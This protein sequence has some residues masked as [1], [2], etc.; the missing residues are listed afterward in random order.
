MTS[1]LDNPDID[2]MDAYFE[3]MIPSSECPLIYHR[4][5]LISIVGA[6]LGRQAHLEFG[7]E[8]IYPNMYVC[9]IGSAG[10]RKSS[11][12]KACRLMLDTTGYAYF[13]RERT[14]KEKF[15]KDMS[16]AKDLPSGGD[17]NSA[18]MLDMD[19]DLNPV[20]DLQDADPSEVYV[21]AGELEDFLGQNDAGFISLLTNLWDNLDKYDHGKMTSHDILIPKPTVNLLG[22]ATSTTFNSVFPPEVIGQGMLSR[23]LLIFGG[24]KRT[25][26]TF[27]PALNPE[28]RKEICD[29][30]A[31]I[32]ETI[33]GGMTV[34]PDTFV[35][36]DTIYKTPFNLGDFRFENYLNRR[37]IHYY[38]LCMIIAAMDLSM[39]ITPVHATKANSILNYAETL[40]PKAL[41]EFGMARN[42]DAVN[43]VNSFIVD[44]YAK[45]HV[46]A[47]I[48]KDV[49]PAV[50]SHFESMSKDFTACMNKLKQ[51][52]K[53]EVVGGRAVPLMSI[54][55]KKIPH[56]DFDSLMEYQDAKK[57]TND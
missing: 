5:G 8:K 4:W 41:G 12:V 53:V 36:W 1:I 47:H 26:I 20:S 52:Q 13:S 6:M 56:V 32:K 44:Y 50:S 43:I 45:N 10:S 7:I 40:M 17:N 28:L 49:W 21:S 11:A 31:A 24:G 54:S 9:L 38:K 18:S 37:H 35:M 2:L 39:E 51:S 19:L 27:P 34:H 46:G 33:V 48:L 42:S 55:A 16:S 14:S 15:L 25:S 30:L 3:L 22:G 57:P 29:M 23:M